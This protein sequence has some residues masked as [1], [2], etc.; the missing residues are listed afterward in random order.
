MRQALLEE[1]LV[2]KADAN[3]LQRITHLTMFFK[4]CYKYISKYRSSRQSKIIST[5]VPNRKRSTSRLC[6][7]TLLVELI[8]R[9]QSTV[10]YVQSTMRNTGL[11]EAGAGI[12]IAGT[13][14]MQRTP[15]L[16]QKVKKNQR[17]S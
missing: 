8:C 1:L 7:V 16:W 5:L 11:D 9:V 17:A 4:C 15:P 6:I 3:P 10:L 14:D 12:K 2:F 13:S